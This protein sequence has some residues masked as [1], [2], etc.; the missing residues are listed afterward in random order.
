M[1]RPW[2][3]LFAILTALG[4]VAG[5]CGDD[6]GGGEGQ[7]SATTFADGGLIGGGDDDDE[8]VTAS[9]GGHIVVGLEGES[10]SWAPGS[11]EWTAGGLSVAYAIYDPLLSLTADGAYEP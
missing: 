6:D 9:Y 11:S 4:L 5:A 10:Q 1:R 7:S 2:W 3:R 8:A